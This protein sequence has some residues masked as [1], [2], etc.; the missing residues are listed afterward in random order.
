MMSDLDW[1]EAFDLYMQLQRKGLSSAD[2]REAMDAYKAN[3]AP[4]WG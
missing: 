2:F 3:R 1:Q 4:K